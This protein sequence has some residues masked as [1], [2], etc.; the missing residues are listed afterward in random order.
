VSRSRAVILPAFAVLA[1]GGFATAA[2]ADNGGG[3]SNKG[4]GG[5]GSTSNRTTTDHDETDDRTTTTTPATTAAPPAPTVQQQQ[6]V[7]PQTTTTTPAADPPPA[8][9]TAR[10]PSTPAPSRGPSV[11]TGQSASSGP[12]RTRPV[13]SRPAPHATVAGARPAQQARA[14][15]DAGRPDPVRPAT[16]RSESLV[17]AGDRPRDDRSIVIFDEALARW[18][19]LVA[20]GV[21]LVTA[22]L[23]AAGF[24]AKRRIL[25]L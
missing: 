13:G 24:W 15:R 4:P 10:E 14:V 19:A 22:V 8:T 25:K 12:T 9:T 1:V 11:R 23:L 5:G 21:L 2:L 17:S 7:A 6:P 20:G 16:Q 3:G 18:I